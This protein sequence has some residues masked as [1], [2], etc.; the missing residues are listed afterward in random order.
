MTFELEISLI[1][2]KAD[3]FHLLVN[4]E[5]KHFNYCGGEKK[6][7][8]LCRDRLAE[9][10]LPNAHVNWQQ[11]SHIYIHTLEKHFSYS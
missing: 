7:H 3:F 6:A 1:H 4:S 2:K 5:D 9:I 10:T 8:T 11:Y